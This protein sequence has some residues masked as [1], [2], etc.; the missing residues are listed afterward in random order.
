MTAYHPA[1]TPAGPSPYDMYR[2]F[3]M[4][5]FAFVCFFVLPMLVVVRILKESPSNYGLRFPTNYS[6]LKFAVFCQVLIAALLYFI[7]SHHSDQRAIFPYSKYLVQSHSVKV[8]AFYSACYFLYYI[9]WEFF[10]LVQV[11]PSAIIH[12]GNPVSMPKTVEETS[13]AVIMGVIWGVM[14]WRTRSILIPFVM[15]YG[16][17]VMFDGFITFSSAN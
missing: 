1:G 10:F 12:L 16:T 7:Y 14:T 9:G 17:G 15:H 11:I 13:S 5:G 3:Y 4:F 2:I 8:F 6:V